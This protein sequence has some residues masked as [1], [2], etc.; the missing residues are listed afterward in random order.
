MAVPLFLACCGEVSEQWSISQRLVASLYLGRKPLAQPLTEAFR[1]LK[2]C[3]VAKQADNVTRAIVNSD[4]V[5]A[6]LEM[7]LD[8]VR[9]FRSEIAFRVVHQLPAY[10]LAV[11]F[12]DAGL[13]R[14][15]ALPFL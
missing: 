6:V 11:Y 14:H 1:Q 15:S 2:Y 8:S 10:F 9:Q 7:S 12:D 5:S 3:P 4:T 13:C